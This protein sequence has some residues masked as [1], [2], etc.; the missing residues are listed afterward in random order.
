MK[1]RKNQFASI[2]TIWERSLK[3]SIIVVRYRNHYRV[4]EEAVSY[5]CIELKATTGLQFFAN[6][7]HNEPFY[8]RQCDSLLLFCVH[9]EKRDFYLSCS[10][11][12]VALSGYL[13]RKQ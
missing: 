11:N 13:M 2:M 6:Q 10:D 9:K 3:S 1:E 7:F 4:Q 12:R 8:E 5:M